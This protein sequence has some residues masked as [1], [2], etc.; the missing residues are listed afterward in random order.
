M[1]C[2]DIKDMLSLYIDGELDDEEKLLLEEHIEGCDDCRKELEEYRKIIGM[3]SSLTDE[4]PPKGYC[5][6]LHEKLVKAKAERPAN[7]RVIWL[8]YGSIA[9][10]LVLV[11]SVVY[12]ASNRGMYRLSGAGKN[13]SYDE[14]AP[15][16]EA[17]AEAPQTESMDYAGGRGSDGSE[18]EKLKTNFEMGLMNGSDEK[19]MQDT[20]DN[21]AA[22]TSASREAKIVK[23]GNIYAET[24]DYD[25]F[26]NDLVTKIQG[27]GGYIEENNT[28][29]RG[30]YGDRELKYGYLKT[31]IPEKNFYEAISYLESSTKV[32][33]K[34]I[35]EADVTKEYYEKDNKVKNLE[36]QENRLRELFDKAENV[37]DMLQIENELRRIRTEIDSLN[38][39]LK[40]IDD[41]ASMST[42]TVEIQEVVKANININ[43]R[44]NVWDRAKA[45]FIGTVNGIVR[46]V[47]N[48][49]IWLVSASPVLI[50]VIIIAVIAVL[51]IRKRK[52]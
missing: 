51:K 10:A 22:L 27:M 45:G 40:D 19:A 25:V 2:N 31:R 8:K 6:R 39:S 7:K 9:A 36:I 23:T 46:L 15:Y 12:L 14:S 32:N 42:I 41:R 18:E 48:F 47:E 37:Q 38:I 3:L 28:N 11:F 30:I 16:I 52:I 50:P 49:I 33:Q 34:N 4:E 17:P 43:P 21:V 26:L 20:S 35:Y 29:I 13:S 44:S 24:E 5:K 1:D